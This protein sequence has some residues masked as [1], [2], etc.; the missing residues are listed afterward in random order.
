MHKT[1]TL[2]HDNAMKCSNVVR[3]GMSLKTVTPQLCMHSWIKN[4][5]CLYKSHAFPLG[6]KLSDVLTGV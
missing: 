2:Q 1:I 5:V 4:L 6:K 3:Q